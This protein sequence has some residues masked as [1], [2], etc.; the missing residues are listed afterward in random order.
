MRI[1]FMMI[2]DAHT[3]I[4]KYDKKIVTPEMTIKALDNAGIDRALVF[5]NEYKTPDFGITTEEIVAS[6]INNPRLYAI[7]TASPFS[8]NV[9]RLGY[10]K[11]I[12]KDRLVRGIKFYLGYE[13]F[14]ASD[15]RLNPLYEI[16]SEESLPA[17]FHTG[18]LFNSKTGLLK[19]AYPLTIDDLA[20]KFPDLKI[21]IAHMG[22]PWITDCAAVAFRH[23]N[24]YL[25]ISGYFTELKKPFAKAEVA[26]FKLDITRL[27]DFFGLGRKIIFATDWPICDMP[28]YLQACENLF[29]NKNE[30]ELFYW[31]NAA[32]LFQLSLS[33]K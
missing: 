22:N 23:P 21:I 17:I 15:E 32:N 3:H 13:H 33:V 5:A 16:L 7:G 9:E 31:K 19:Y 20:V 4:G 25:D 6:A 8:L 14:Y 30:K 1:K 24:V 2:I 18:Y 26:A 28:E 29:S 27:R 10:L 11:G 12:I